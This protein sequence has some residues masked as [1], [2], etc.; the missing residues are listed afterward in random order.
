MANIASSYQAL[1]RHE[2]AFRLCEEALALRRVHLGPDHEDTL[3]S[4]Y[5]LGAGHAA[6]KLFDEAFKVH[7]E[8][9]AGRQAKLGPAHP[10]TLDSM[11]AV[12]GALASAGRGADAV[13]II[14]DCVR[15]AAGQRVQP[16]LYA[17]VLDTRLRHYQ[18]TNDAAGCRATAEM[19]ENLGRTDVVALYTAARFRAVTAKVFGATDAKESD[20]EADRAVEW[21]RKAFAAGFTEVASLMK[22]KDFDAL[23][24][25]AEF[26]ELMTKR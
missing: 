9:L 12:A 14:D 20:A 10:H 22:E 6:Q 18:S 2:E 8:A 24:E 13:P 1:G 21:L 19:W 11:A 26:R 15:R 7:E 4:L 16:R 17:E 5:N 23:R 25:R 3:H